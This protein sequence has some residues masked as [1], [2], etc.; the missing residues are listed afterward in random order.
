MPRWPAQVVEGEVTGGT[1]PSPGA[2][3]PPGAKTSPPGAKTRPP[4]AKT[5][6]ASKSVS[7][8]VTQNIPGVTASQVSSTRGGG[9]GWVGRCVKG[10]GSPR[11]RAATCT[12]QVDTQK[13]GSGMA[14]ALNKNLAAKG[15]TC[16]VTATA[17]NQ[18]PSGQGRRLHQDAGSYGGY[19]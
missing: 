13:L 4:G 11:V 12:P 14:D 8:K 1:S 9:A 16:T 15:Q 10:A 19:G 6:P 17:T 18:A 3:T 2:K 5:P 7:V